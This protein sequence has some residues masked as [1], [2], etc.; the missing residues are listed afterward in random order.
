MEV[1]EPRRGAQSR[2]NAGIAMTREDVELVRRLYEEIRWVN[3]DRRDALA[4]VE[5][6]N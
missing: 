4:A 1:P 2:G 3:P 5:L 6:G